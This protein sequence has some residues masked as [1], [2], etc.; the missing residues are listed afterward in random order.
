MK[1]QLYQTLPHKNNMT[2]VSDDAL[3]PSQVLSLGRTSFSPQSSTLLRSAD[4]SRH[5]SS[6]LGPSDVLSAQVEPLV[7]SAQV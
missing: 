4:Q 7:L 3:T 5:V 1:P 2:F 6:V